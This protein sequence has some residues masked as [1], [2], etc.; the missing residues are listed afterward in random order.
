VLRDGQKLV[1]AQHFDSATIKYKIS[2]L[3]QVYTMFSER[4]QQQQNVLNQAVKFMRSSVP[5]S[6]SVYVQDFSFF[7]HFSTTTKLSGF[8]ALN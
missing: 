1:N 5:V 3:D 2:R 8:K 7:K 6:I 4:L